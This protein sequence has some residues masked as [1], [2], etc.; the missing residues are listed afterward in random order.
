[1]VST[2]PRRNASAHENE[3]ESLTSGQWV[4]RYVLLEKLG[5]GGMGV[6]YAAFDREL[7]RKVALKFISVAANASQAA[8][9]LPANTAKI[10]SPEQLWHRLL[11]REAQA[12]A[13][14]A[15]PNILPIYDVGYHGTNIYVAM[16]FVAG[17]TLRQW[18]SLTQRSWQE[19]LTVMIAAGEGLYAAHQAGLIHRDFKPDNLL[20]GLDGR[21]RVFDFGLVK[22]SREKTSLERFGSSDLLA[23]TTERETVFTSDSGSSLA[24]VD[25]ILGTPSYMAP[26]QYDVDQTT[27]ASDQFSYCVA[28][29]EALYRQKPFVGEGIAGIRKAVLRGEITWPSKSHKVPKWLRRVL[30]R[31]LSADPL[32]RFGSMHE[33]LA[34]LDQLPRLRQQRG[35]AIAG[36]AFALVLGLGIASLTELNQAQGKCTANWT[37]RE[38]IWTDLRMNAVRQAFLR[39]ESR[40]S[41]A[42]LDPVFAALQAQANDLDSAYESL[43]EAH[44]SGE[45]RSTKYDIASTCLRS[46]L[47]QFDV[48]VAALAK[49]DRS[50]LDHATKAIS[51]LDN[52]NSCASGEEDNH[53]EAFFIRDETLASEIQ[54]GASEAR[55][56]ALTG[57]REKAKAKA[58]H[59]LEQAVKLGL[60]STMSD[61]SMLLGE[62][63]SQ[64]FLGTKALNSVRKAL[65][66]ARAAGA[67]QK[68]FDSAGSLLFVQGY[69]LGDT[70]ELDEM[71]GLGE[72]SLLRRGENEVRRAELRMRSGAALSAANRLAEAESYFTL[73][74][75]GLQRHYG[76]H[77]PRTANA[78]NSLGVTYIFRRRPRDAL[79]LLEQ[80]QAISEQ[81]LGVGHPTS[82]LAM[83][84]L[85]EISRATGF[86]ARSL[87]YQERAREVYES[88]AGRPDVPEALRAYAGMA[89]TLYDLGRKRDAVQALEQSLRAIANK[90]PPDDLGRG[91]AIGMLAWIDLDFGKPEQAL[92]R[93]DAEVQRS[94]ARGRGPVDG[95]EPDL[96][97]ARVRLLIES[98]DF[99]AAQSWVELA[100]PRLVRYDASNGHQS[101]WLAVLR[102]RIAMHRGEMRQAKQHTD[103][104]LE[105]WRAGDSERTAYLS[106]AL[107]QRAEILMASGDLE[108]ARRQWLE[109]EELVSRDAN[110][111]HPWRAMALQRL[112]ETAILPAERDLARNWAEQSIE[113][114]DVDEEDPRLVMRR[115]EQLKRLTM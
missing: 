40:F 38:E 25:D 56:L 20:I 28:F 65:L 51:G 75:A 47:R 100:R 21:V 83:T 93:L 26:E 80:A 85:G 104:A 67:D 6:V 91:E 4:G 90:S 16:E 5:E 81:S 111:V 94:L 98:G 44:A 9:E 77:D 41:R 74:L 76:L 66:Y 69:Q 22:E 96:F 10:E 34:A 92:A 35:L 46:R 82:L 84:N 107:L 101:A 37:R 29:F 43:C 110:R 73:A 114:T 8:D 105:L 13:K 112:A 78:L 31:G 24:T 12:M 45:I 48:L 14:L 62:I 99:D 89:R 79:P 18:F 95:Q 70:S 54:A 2:I 106:P 102:A 53:E 97:V 60:F 59:L 30:V 11:L 27:V 71:L 15:H 3:C 1:V 52:V 113:A 42:N 86:F 109:V 63:D 103:E 115:R 58:E 68:L 32:Q 49:G 19:V 7:A 50:T 87:A 61:L 72:S 39:Q 55:M 88:Q 57:A 36:G 33:L 17:H 108:A 23:A 64:A